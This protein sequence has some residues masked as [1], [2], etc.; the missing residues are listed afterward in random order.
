LGKRLPEHILSHL[1][2]GLKEKGRFLTDYGF[3][4]E[5]TKS[6][7]YETD[8]YWRGPIWAPSTMI[9]LDGLANAGEEEFAREIAYKFCSMCKKSGM[10]ENFN[11]LTGEAL[12]DNAYTWTSSVFLILAN[13]F[14]L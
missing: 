2:A 11:A 4:T 9:I 7:Y 3:A 14:L 10:A 6:R 13:K 12:R 1:I 8:G 5:S